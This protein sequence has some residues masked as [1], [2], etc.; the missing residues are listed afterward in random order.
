[1]TKGPQM[2]PRCVIAFTGAQGTGKSTLVKAIA[3]E[4]AARGLGQC[5][6]YR[7]IGQ[8]AA[9][10]GIPLG[11]KADS[12][13]IMEFARLHVRRERGISGHGIHLLDRCFVDLLAYAR[14]KCH[15]Q[16]SL[17]RLVEELA[18]SSLQGIDLVVRVPMIDSLRMNY[19]SHETSDFRSVIDE[20]IDRIMSELQVG[21]L[22]VSGMPSERAGQVVSWING[23]FG[24]Q[25]K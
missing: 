24:V 1:M 11:G 3:G 4:V 13:T 15:E 2:L 16:P 10:Q 21:Y 22:T 9:D 19:S 6:V 14:A 8:E 18:R 7:G 23:F 20:S 17:V 5:T 25:D 12:T